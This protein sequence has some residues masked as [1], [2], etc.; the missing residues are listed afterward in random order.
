MV[1]SAPLAYMRHSLIRHVI[2]PFSSPILIFNSLFSHQFCSTEV[3]SRSFFGLPISLPFPL[4]FLLRF[5][6]PFFFTSPN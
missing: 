2:L 4:P 6:L 3:P 1:E 5:P